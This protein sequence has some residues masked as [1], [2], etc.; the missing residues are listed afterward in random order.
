M[1]EAG[2]GRAVG[3][4][5][6]GV[7]RVSWCCSKGRSRAMK[8]MPGFDCD[9]RAYY[10]RAVLK[11]L[12][13]YAVDRFAGRDRAGAVEAVADFAAGVD[14]RAGEH[15]RREIVERHGIALGVGRVGI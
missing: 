2:M 10:E 15:R 13:Q 5:N 3:P 12:R 9:E 4:W 6:E 1:A 8:T 14:S 7:L 11:D